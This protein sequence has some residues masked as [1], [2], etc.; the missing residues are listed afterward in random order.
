VPP[1]WSK[2]DGEKIHIGLSRTR[3]TKSRIAAVLKALHDGEKTRSEPEHQ[4][5][6]DGPPAEIQPITESL[7]WC[8]DFRYKVNNYTQWKSMAAR[9]AKLYPN[10]QWTTNHNAHG[11]DCT[12][13]QDT[14][15]N[16]QKRP[17]IKGAPPIVMLGNVH[18]PAAVY[19]DSQAAAKQTGATLVTYEGYGHT[20]Y[21]STAKAGP[22]T[23]INDLIDDYLINLKVPVKGI[24]C[25]DIETPQ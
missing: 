20:V 24:R 5:Q 4:E 16:P 12:G 21:P 15:T 23:C 17:D 13:W 3:A 1:D 9:L 14:T 22:V 7:Y 25:P 18:D 10:V 11:L 6:Q 19:Q 2:P 8:K